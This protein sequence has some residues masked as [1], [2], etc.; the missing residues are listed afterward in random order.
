MNYFGY[1]VLMVMN[2]TDVDDKIIYRSGIVYFYN[3]RYEVCS[4][5]QVTSPFYYLKGTGVH[6]DSLM[7]PGELQCHFKTKF[8]GI[9]QGD[10]KFSS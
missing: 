8:D 9:G 1:D 6:P 4:Y 10:I 7:F 5:P 2:I 3:L